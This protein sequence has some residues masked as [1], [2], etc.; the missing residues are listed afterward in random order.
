MIR[1]TGVEGK[2]FVLDLVSDMEGTI[3]LTGGISKDVDEN[4]CTLEELKY[5]ETSFKTKRVS[6]SVGDFRKVVERI[7]ALSSSSGGGAVSS[8]NG[9]IGDVIID[10]SEIELLDGT[11]IEEKVSGLKSVAFSG[12]YS[13]LIGRPSGVAGEPYSVKSWNPYRV[14]SVDIYGSALQEEFIGS[15]STDAVL[16]VDET[17]DE[18]R[19]KTQ[20][21]RMVQSVD[22]IMTILW[23]QIAQVLD[24]DVQHFGNLFQVDVF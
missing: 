6:M 8:V 17:T 23:I 4:I 2:L 18:G 21:H 10:A 24:V 9:E 15:V 19:W 7:A 14:D 16:L 12:N 3:S 1:L 22:D 20:Y 13:D 5:I 11:S